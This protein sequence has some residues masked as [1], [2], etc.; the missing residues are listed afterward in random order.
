MNFTIQSKWKLF[1]SKSY[2]Y[3]SIETEK[4]RSNRILILK[5]EERVKEARKIG[6]KRD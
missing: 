5:R 6:Q 1:Y 3:N 2:K 4:R